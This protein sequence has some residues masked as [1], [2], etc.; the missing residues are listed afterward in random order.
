MGDPRYNFSTATKP[1]RTANEVRIAAATAVPAGDADERYQACS[2]ATAPPFGQLG[3]SQIRAGVTTPAHSH[4]YPA[5]HGC[6]EGP[7][8]LLTPVAEQRLETGLFCLLA[9]HLRHQWHNPGPRPAA[10]LEFILNTDHPGTW[11]AET[12]LGDCCRA[13]PSLVQGVH[14]FPRPGDREL[15]Q[16]FWQVADCLLDERPRHALTTTGLLCAFTGLLLERLRPAPD[17]PAYASQVAHQMR[18]LLLTRVR[19]RLS[20]AEV[21]N[22]V[23]LSPTRAKEVFRITYGCGIMT[24]F[25]GLKIGQAK[26]LLGDLSLT[27][28]QVSKSLGFSSPSYFSRVFH[29]RTGWSPIAYRGRTAQATTPAGRCKE[30]R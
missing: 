6:L 2:Q 9:P 23:G 14:R 15:Y 28:D 7:L 1:S 18:R 27:V 30:A 26:R 12:G 29:Q 16:Y 21:A 11:P 19:D 25:T 10:T 4:P 24:Y 5:V 8:T 3:S 13:L 20:V 17:P 22:H